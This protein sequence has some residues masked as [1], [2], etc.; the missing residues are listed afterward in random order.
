MNEKLKLILFI[1]GISILFAGGIMAIIIP[2]IINTNWY[3]LFSIFLFVLAMAFPVMCNAHQFV[4]SGNSFLFDEGQEDLGGML[5]WFLAGSCLTIAYSIPFLLW[6][7]MVM[8][9]VNMI[10]TMSGGTV[11]I[12][13]LGLFGYFILLNKNEFD[14]FSN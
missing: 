6:H 11:M 2:C 5:A 13:A 14:L 7:K 3:S 10:C 8:N 12:V 9:L 1:V 4:N